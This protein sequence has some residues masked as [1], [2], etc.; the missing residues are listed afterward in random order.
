MK[1]YLMSCCL[2]I[3][4]LGGFV[5]VYGT[6]GDTQ[7]ANGGETYSGSTC[8]TS[9][10]KTVHWKVYWLDGYD[11]AVDITDNGN[12]SNNIIGCSGCWPAFHSPFFSEVSNTG[13]L[14]SIDE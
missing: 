8:Q 13:I 12:G 6:C 1:S 4:F 14:G 9:F 3:F 10:S 5:R 11:R 7:N 2:M